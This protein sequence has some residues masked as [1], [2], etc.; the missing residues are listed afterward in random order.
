MCGKTELLPPIRRSLRYEDQGDDDA[1]QKNGP[2][3]M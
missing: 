3:L 2:Y 1:V